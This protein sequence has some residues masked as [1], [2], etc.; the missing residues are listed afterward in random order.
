MNAKFFRSMLSMILCAQALL[1]RAPLMAQT[2]Q[3]QV[4]TENIFLKNY[5]DG[6][7]WFPNVVQPYQTQAFPPFQIE[8]S[9]RLHN[10]IHD[11][12]LEI[13]MADA[14][15]LAI[16]N[17]LDIAVQRYI[18]PIAQTDVL[19]TKSGQAARG[20]TG[21]LIPGGL[22]AGALGAGV[23]TAS[24]AS[25]FG[26]A[27]GITGG[28]G[29]VVIG[30]SGTFDPTLSFNYSWDKATSPLNTIQVSGNPSVSVTSNAFSGAYT[31]LLPTGTSYFV[32]L[33]G[34][35]QNS[36]QQFLLF[37]PAVITRFTLGFNQ[38]LLNGFGLLPNER[39]LIVARNN[40]KVS[41]EVFRLQV[42]T[43]VVKV[44]NTYWDMVSFQ[45]N[46]KVAQ[47]SLA[48]AEKLLKENRMKAEIGT[49]APLDVTSAQSE[50]ASRQR[51]LIV[52]QT[53]LQLQETTLKNI[54]SVK[55]DPLLDAAHIVTKDPLPAVLSQLPDL[56]RSLAS[57]YENRPDLRESQAN[58]QNQNT[59]VSYTRTNLRPNLAIFG[60]YAG[61]GLDGTTPTTSSGGGGS[62][63]GQ[64]FAGDYPEQ[65]AG[66]SINVP[67][68]NRAAQADDIRA[69]LERSQLQVGLQR[70]RNQI[71][72]EVRQALIGL[73]Q[74]KAQVEAAH[75]AVILAKQTLDAEQQKLEAGVSTSYNEILRER[76]LISAQLAEV[77]A[78]VSYAK[79]LVEMD[80]ATG[81][82][83][84]QNGI[85]LSDAAGGT[86][87]SMPKPMAG[88]AGLPTGGK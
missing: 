85:Q 16:E 46:V 20:F 63:F 6:V 33:N 50:V 21:A 88:T 51:D 14:L 11:G 27:G 65:A 23:S 54:L 53:N 13:T 28:G 9:A 79:A 42:I 70:T 15:A 66:L 34:L 17:N 18:L 55:M 40:R 68:R 24:N 26:S 59:A 47:Q 8:N 64:A 71:S 56:E 58:L 12:K 80:R 32:G 10:L 22:S 75:Q 60:M 2:A 38:P 83:L 29:S 35:W 67:I 48:V 39:F 82:T 36:T 78:N 69:Q 41:E 31:Q 52:A 37:N 61:S 30:P 62:S 72:L 4:A 25:G 81:A 76:D 7:G 44:A 73:I 1:P 74:G 5:T 3:P 45:E 77:Q 87:T 86:I 19:R 84:D 49:M 43:T 57:A